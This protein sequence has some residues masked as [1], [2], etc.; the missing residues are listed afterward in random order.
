MSKWLV[1]LLLV[2]LFPLSFFFLLLLLTFSIGPALIE[3]CMFKCRC[4]FEETF[5]PF[6]SLLQVQII[7]FNSDL[8]SSVALAAKNPNG[9]VSISLLIQVSTLN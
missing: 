8:Y 4:N 1:C 7:G 2:P 9:L 5:E 3:L 6:F